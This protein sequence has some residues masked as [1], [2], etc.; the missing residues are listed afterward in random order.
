MATLSLIA[1]PTNV[2][3][4]SYCDVGFADAYHSARIRK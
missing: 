3:A 4:N 1:D 2:N